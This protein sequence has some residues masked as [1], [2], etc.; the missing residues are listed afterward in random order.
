MSEKHEVAVIKKNTNGLTAIASGHTIDDD[1]NLT[2]NNLSV[3]TLDHNNILNI[4]YK[5]N[6]DKESILTSIKYNANNQYFEFYVSIKIDPYIVPEPPVIVTIT[7]V[8]NSSNTVT[9][10]ANVSNLQSGEIINMYSW[11]VNNTTR[12]HT[13]D[14][15]NTIDEIDLDQYRNDIVTVIVNTN[16]ITGINSADYLIPSVNIDGIVSGDSVTITATTT[17][18]DQ[19]TSYVWLFQN[20][21]QNELSV[22]WN[23]IHDN[24]N[25]NTTISLSS[26]QNTEIRVIV[27]NNIESNYYTIPFVDG[28]VG[29]GGGGGSE[30]GGGGGSESGVVDSK[31]P[32]Q[33]E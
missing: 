20:Q 1:G 18:I 2:V 26:Y 23:I 6:N 8:I 17:N 19:N 24:D 31:Q 4:M 32:Q 13:S 7:G 29:G 11:Y 21:N 10:T 22:E 27:N 25:N 30:S 33:I 14:D 12:I 3:T 5:H 16:K 9:L 15:S 28:G